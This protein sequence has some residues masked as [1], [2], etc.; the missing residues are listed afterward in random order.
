[1]AGSSFVLKFP[2]KPTDLL[3]AAVVVGIK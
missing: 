3:A 1:V 2:F